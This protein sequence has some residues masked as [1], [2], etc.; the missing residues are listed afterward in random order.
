MLI[1]ITFL[2]KNEFSIKG[3]KLQFKGKLNKGG[4]RKKKVKYRWGLSSLTSKNLRITKLI[5][6]FRTLPGSIS[7]KYYL[8]Y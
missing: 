6:S 8:F 2:F 1:K 4:S 5:D 7:C 3:V